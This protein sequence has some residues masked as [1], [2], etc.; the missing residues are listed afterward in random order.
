MTYEFVPDEKDYLNYLYYVTTKSQKVRKKRAMNKLVI[1]FLYF[2]AGLF[3]YNSQ[4]PVNAGIFFL[5]CLPVYFLYG[6]FEK[7]Q[8]LRHFTK[9]IKANYSQEI[10][11][12]TTIDSDGEGI[13]ISVGD[14]KT[15]M[16]WSEVVKINETG[17]LLLIEEKNQNA[18]VIPKQKTNHAGEL[19][20]ELKAIASDH[21]IQ[22]ITEL[23]WKWK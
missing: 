15:K 9:Y 22:Y 18:I 4:G 23:D 8:Y 16:A 3:L 13:S 5:L 2:I 6:Y 21:N 17:E 14:S 10:G 1:L 19:I 7:R 20:S 12:H 11:V